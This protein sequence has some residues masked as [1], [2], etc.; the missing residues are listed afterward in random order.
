MEESED[1]GEI[2]S[3]MGAKR[4]QIKFA[5]NWKGKQMEIGRRTLFRILKTRLEGCGGCFF[6]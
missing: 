2:V 6:Q 4:E 3:Q 5:V 1:A